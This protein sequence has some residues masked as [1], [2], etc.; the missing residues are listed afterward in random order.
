MYIYIY[1][2]CMFVLAH[3]FAIYSLFLFVDPPSLS[4]SSSLSLSLSLSPSPF[5]CSFLDYSAFRW[6]LPIHATCFRL[7]RFRL[8]GDLKPRAGDGDLRVGLPLGQQKD[9]RLCASFVSSAIEVSGSS[10]KCNTRQ[11]AFFWDGGVLLARLRYLRVLV[12][13]CLQ[14]S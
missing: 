13:M 10:K 6:L 12:C 4:L 11:P 8:P 7:S 2:L 5:V 3:L 14:S 1:N 9:Y